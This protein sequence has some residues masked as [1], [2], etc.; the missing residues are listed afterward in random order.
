M[1][2]QK[3]PIHLFL[4]ILLLFSCDNKDEI[5]P[6]PDSTKNPELII[7]KGEEL[8]G[9]A[10]S[11]LLATQTAFEQQIGKP[12]FEDFSSFA[13]GNSLFKQSWVSAPASTT[14]RDGLGPR[15][16]A[17][18]CSGCH[19]KDGRGKPFGESQGLLLRLSIPGKTKNGGPLPHPVYGGQLQD[20]AIQ[21]IMSEG[22]FDIIYTEI[23]G[24]YSDGAPYSLRK[25]EYKLM[26]LSFGDIGKDILISPRVGQQMIGMGLLEAIPEDTL[27]AWADK[28][29]TN[30]DG[31]SGK[32]NYV[33]DAQKQEK[34]IGRFGW[35]AN[36]PNI[37][38]QVAGALLGDLGITSSLNPNENCL[39]G[40]CE[41]LPD[42]GK[43]EINE[44]SLNDMTLY[45]RS[46]AVPIRRN[47]KDTVVMRGK[48][49]FIDLNCNSCHKM[50]VKTG[51]SDILAFANQTIR[52]YTDLLLH[53]MGEGLADNR[54]DFDATG[55]EWRTPPLWGIGLIK[56]V[57]NH[58]FFLHDGR[59]R[60]I[61]EAIL[62][63]GGE[64]ENSKNEFTKLIKE[65]RNQLI[66]FLNSL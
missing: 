8:L 41:D 65:K 56:T 3:L 21:G 62:W 66:V 39:T 60:N 33:W 1:T 11:T 32:V 17:R 61:E 53:D 47:W 34:S 5:I 52:P 45:S 29:D 40:D 4:I 23:K 51:S 55:K 43:P 18:S 24:T 57:N 28:N 37:K 38:Q 15:F 42:G 25:P 2:T 20:H 14:A 64:A 35:K 63:H 59:A 19:P 48:Q 30:I 12:S 9:G 22:G 44:K 7:E 6:L 58:T 36:Q 50:K 26:N 10:H 13:V 49:L 16:N 54:P 46:L 27:V 31:I